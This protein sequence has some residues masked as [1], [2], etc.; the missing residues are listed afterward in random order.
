MFL[1]RK[2][3][4]GTP[5]AWCL[6]LDR[7]TEESREQSARL[8]APVF[9]L[10]H[11]DSLE[12]LGSLPLALIDDLSEETALKLQEYLAGSGAEI[13]ITCDKSL[14]QKCF[15]TLWPEAPDLSFLD[16][17]GR[18]EADDM[19]P[20][21][22]SNAADPVS[23]AT[24]E[25]TVEVPADEEPAPSPDAL[26]FPEVPET[27]LHSVQE[28]TGPLMAFCSTELELLIG[29]VELWKKECSVWQQKI[30]QIDGRLGNLYEERNHLTQRFLNVEFL[31]QA[32]QD[33]IGKLLDAL[34]ALD[35]KCR[36]FEAD[37]REARH[38]F[39]QNLN[40]FIQEMEGWRPKAEDMVHSL[41]SF[42][43]A[44]AELE[45][46]MRRM[47]SL[48]RQREEERRQSDE[49]IRELKGI[50]AEAQS[51]RAASEASLGDV[52]RREEDL[53]AKIENIER[54]YRAE[55]EKL[56][57][58]ARQ[59]GEETAEIR[60]LLKTIESE[61]FRLRGE[62]ENKGGI[63]NE[64]SRARVHIGELEDE[65]ACLGSTLRDKEGLEPSLASARDTIRELEGQIAELEEKTARKGEL[66][67][68][69][70]AVSG[71][72]SE[73]EAS[74]ENAE[75]RA[76]E[77][78]AGLAASGERCRSLEAE[79]AGLREAL[80]QKD[81][82]EGELSGASQRIR[83]VEA[84]MA[85][86]GERYRTLE[87]ET[88]GLREALNRKHSLEQELSGSAARV[89]ELEAV[90]QDTGNRVREM[91]KESADLRETLK[92]R[93]HA[94]A[95]LKDSRES[96]S[97]LAKDLEETRVRVSELEFEAAGLRE[98]LSGKTDLEAACSGLESRIHELESEIKV[99]A[100]KLAEKEGL[101]R[102]LDEAREGLEQAAA[103]RAEVDRLQ[104]ENRHIRQE[105]ERN[106][107]ALES[108][109]SEAELAGYAMKEQVDEK[110]RELSAL[111][112]RMNLEREELQRSLEGGAAERAAHQ[113][114]LEQTLAVK[115]KELQDLRAQIESG[116][117]DR[118][119]LRQQTQ[120]RLQ[121]LDENLR[122]TE[123]E[124]D[125]LRDREK[126][127]EQRVSALADEA[128]EFKSRIHTL[129]H[130]WRQR[131]SSL[132]AEVQAARE[133]QSVSGEERLRKQEEAIADLTRERDGL[134]ARLED[135]T[136]QIRSREEEFS[137]GLEEM[138]H[139]LDESR[140]VVEE[141]KAKNTALESRLQAQ[142]A[143]RKES[144]DPKPAASDDHALAEL[145]SRIDKRIEEWHG[146]C[147]E[148][149]DKVKTLQNAEMRLLME[150]GRTQ[151][152]YN[153]K[154]KISE[155]N[156][157]LVELRDSCQTLRKEIGRSGG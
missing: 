64:L 140:R 14:K 54:E 40:F 49:K 31:A 104:D 65:I 149:S 146:R 39:A 98:A 93:E 4:K 125:V 156:K 61:S 56:R 55:V 136:V 153:W 35:G 23:G 75:K 78:E 20:D 3:A 143:G 83:E 121:E 105:A 59:A 57:D 34:L 155:L 29:K 147:L 28:H 95:D 144:P 73:M 101:E 67:A 8:I 70:S 131:A 71:R 128:A 37:Y 19:I 27:S 148:I 36:G 48:S 32:R 138:K 47:E 84:G 77:A 21:E 38:K 135:L 129:D 141:W 18:D 15:R 53:K 123:A 145:C 2:K 132:E 1:G 92:R 79:S 25:E 106:Q 74:L 26:F 124:R 10:S 13:R 62:L 90:L 43:A 51:L 134:N 120:T 46:T 30:E 91:E 42:E 89:K 52:T 122:K 116:I 127:L 81:R 87:N 100:E 9:G 108:R 41:R 58:E 107:A 126:E 80:K 68:E 152:A 69:I 118:E 11:A 130:D 110:V 72:I 133:K 137:R 5:T 102:G 44:R 96:A 150:L 17:S 45:D 50:A 142:E 88:A 12:L 24:A 157:S 82:I 114:R 94:E 111:Q 22:E 154:F 99:Q 97:R 115:E 7:L 103:L 60:E 113:G 117:R 139:E 86:A 33:D 85:A 66:E 76:R 63:E 119:T 6:I 16:E 151:D 109:C 112:D